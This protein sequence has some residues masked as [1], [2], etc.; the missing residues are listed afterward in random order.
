MIGVTNNS[1]TQINAALIALKGEVKNEVKNEIINNIDNSVIG[2]TYTAGDGIDITNAVISQ[3]TDQL[4]FTGT[5]AQWE[6]LTSAEKAKYGLVNRTDNNKGVYKN[7]NGTLELIAGGGV[8]NK[9]KGS[10][11]VPAISSTEQWKDQTITFATPMPDNDYLVVLSIQGSNTHRVAFQVLEHTKT[12]NGFTVRYTP[13]SIKDTVR[14]GVDGVAT[15]TG[16]LLVGHRNSTYH[17]LF[18]N[19]GIYRGDYTIPS[20]DWN[21][22]KTE[23]LRYEMPANNATL[24]YTAFKI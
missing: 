9:R 21:Q 3:T 5:Q 19:W 1:P 16:Y 23:Y 12:V 11:T 18:D 15:D 22:I 7:N 14:V 10:V 4:T 20:P 2:E 8:G 17:N 13:I 6:A 24:C